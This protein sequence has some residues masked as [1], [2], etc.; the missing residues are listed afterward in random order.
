[1]A[2]GRR[3]EGFAETDHRSGIEVFRVLDG[4]ESDPISD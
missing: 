1:M 2:G 4:I 3:P